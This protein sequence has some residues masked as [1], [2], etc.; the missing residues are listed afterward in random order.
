LVLSELLLQAI[1]TNKEEIPVVTS[2]LELATN[3]A[4]GFV[5]V[6]PDSPACR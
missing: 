1:I 4:D 2:I 5:K 3:I 6:Y